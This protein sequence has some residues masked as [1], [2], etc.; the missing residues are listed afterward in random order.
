M[1]PV[2][3]APSCRR[4]RRCVITARNADRSRASASERFLDKDDDD[5]SVG[6]SAAVAPS[7]SS[8]LLSCPPL[9]PPLCGVALLERF[10]LSHGKFPPPPPPFITAVALRELG[11]GSGEAAR[12]ALAMMG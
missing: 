3:H 8:R 1:V 9:G 6:P 10:L 2:T 12:N 5:C 7:V 4:R 11:R